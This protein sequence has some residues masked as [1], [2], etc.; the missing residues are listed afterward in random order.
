LAIIS[1][2]N[3]GCRLVGE[4]G[5]ADEAISVCERFAPD[6]LLADLNIPGGGGVPMLTR[7]K[8]IGPA[9]RILLYCSQANERDVLAA[10]RAG[11]DGF[12]ELTCSRSDFLEAVDRLADGDSYLCPKSVNALARSLRETATH[13]ASKSQNGQLTTREKEV[14]ALIAAGNSSKE[15]A[16]KL[17]LSVSTVE[18]HRANLMAKIGA[19]NIAQLIQY[20][21]REGLTDFPAASAP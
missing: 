12:L 1:Q 16:K 21:L 5:T 10:F 20:A 9:T 14:L 6:L 7:I 15:I 4:A 11:A 19:R 3:G 18:T 13:A 17:F 8:Q 2:N